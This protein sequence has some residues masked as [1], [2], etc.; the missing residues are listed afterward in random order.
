MAMCIRLV[1][2]NCAASIEA[3][4][5]G[6]PYYLD[7]QGQKQ[8]AYHPNPQREL[9][10]GNDSPGICLD[11]GQQFTND[12]REPMTNCVGCQSSNLVDNFALAGRVCPSCKLGVFAADPNFFCIS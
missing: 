4:D 1:C 3:W 9:C 7:K 11:C 12:S 6:N 8:Y 2:Q 5:E 10:I